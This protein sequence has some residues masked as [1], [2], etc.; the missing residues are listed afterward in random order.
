MSRLII[1]LFSM[2]SAFHGFEAAGSEPTA[3]AK[4][5]KAK[6]TVTD[7]SSAIS[8]ETSA[9]QSLEPKNPR[10]K[11]KRKIK[12][13]ATDESTST[14]E[15]EATADA[16]KL[17][18]SRTNRTKQRQNYSL[19]YTPVSDFILQ[20]GAQAQIV[21]SPSLQLGFMVL[22]GSETWGQDYE[23]GVIKLN[24]NGTAFSLTARYFLG[25]SFNVL[26]GLGYRAATVK[27][28]IEHIVLGQVAGDFKVQSATIPLFIGNQWTWPGGFTLGVDWIG[29]WIP[30]SGET[31]VSF[32]GDL[33]QKDMEELT[34][35]FMDAGD[36]LAKKT[37]LTLFLTS[38]GWAF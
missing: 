1:I 20:F 22:T 34:D 27:I 30:I 31:Q 29:A 14:P 13:P 17:E 36:G 15:G 7:E 32:K 4:K 6:G 35:L 18:D 26:T 12:K 11:K 24:G 9:D 37:S 5:S 21:R 33:P 16:S 25:N 38:I 23:R 10:K 8:I 28:D 2:I 19:L 3:E